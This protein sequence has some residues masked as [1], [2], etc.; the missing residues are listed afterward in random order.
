M[1]GTSTYT[2]LNHDLNSDCDPTVYYGDHHQHTNSDPGKDSAVSSKPEAAGSKRISMAVHAADTGEKNDNICNHEFVDVD[3][4]VEKAGELRLLL[5]DS[6]ATHPWSERG[7]ERMDDKTKLLLGG[8]GLALY[9]MAF[10]LIVKYLVVK[11]SGSEDARLSW[12][13]WT[14]ARST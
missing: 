7:L 1:T 2:P 8:L 13:W 12:E 14:G 10:T 11:D 4:D 3:L 6:F 5:E 9:A